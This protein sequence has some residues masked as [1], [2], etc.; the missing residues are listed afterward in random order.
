MTPSGWKCR[1]SSN[2]DAEG[3]G[4]RVGLG[5][6][7]NGQCVLMQNGLEWG[8]KLVAEGE[9][10]EFFENEKEKER[11]RKLSSTEGTKKGGRRNREGR[12]G[13]WNRFERERI[14]SG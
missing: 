5:R 8:R 9:G 6:G 3:R 13:R 10:N 7:R 14:G 4:I 2:T 12:G 1:P 11:V